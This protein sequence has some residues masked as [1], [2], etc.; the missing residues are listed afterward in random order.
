M[1][2]RSLATFDLNCEILFHNVYLSAVV[3][4]LP[5]EWTSEEGWLKH[6]LNYKELRYDK[7]NTDKLSGCN[8]KLSL[9]IKIVTNH[10]RSKQNCIT[11]VSKKGS[12][13]TFI[14][15]CFFLANTGPPSF[16][17]TANNLTNLS[18]VYILII[19]TSTTF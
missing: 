3:Q 9:H 16:F 11:K 5:K 18:N 17:T 1:S 4:P 8:N 2:A 15:T 13:S 6:K 10:N 19:I 14:L 7:K 12:A